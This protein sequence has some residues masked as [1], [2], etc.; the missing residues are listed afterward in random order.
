MNVYGMTT[1]QWALIKRVEEMAMDV[2]NRG[3]HPRFAVVGMYDAD[4]LRGAGYG[5]SV[6]PTPYGEIELLFSQTLE[7][8]FVFVG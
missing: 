4:S 1:E 3:G 2:V 6:V 5:Y 7:L 8:G